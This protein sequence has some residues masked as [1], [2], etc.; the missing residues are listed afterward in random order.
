M[1]ETLPTAELE[2]FVDG[3]AREAMTRDHIAGATVAVVQNGQVLL[4]KGYG[5]AALAPW[6]PVNA[7]TTL[8]RLGPVSR[9]FTWMLVGEQIQAGRMRAEGP[10][11]L[12]LP[13]RLRLPDQG[14]ARPIHIQD[15]MDHTDG[16]ENRALGQAYERDARAIRPLAQYLREE[17]PRRVREPGALPVD[18]DYGSALAGEAVANATGDEFDTLAE[19]RIF[20]PMGLAH[21]SFRE[22]YPARSNLPAPLD[23]ALASQMSDSFEWTSQGLVRQPFAF[24]SQ[25]A[26]SGSASSTAA[27]MARFMS[28]VLPTTAVAAAWPWRS[29]LTPTDLPGGVVGLSEEGRAMSSFASIAFAPSLG[30]GVFVAANTDTAGPMTRDV[31]SQIIQRF[32]AGPMQAPVSGSGLLKARGALEGVYLDDRRAYGRLEGFV[33]RL[34]K[35]V[36][37]HVD[38]DETLRLDSGQTPAIYTVDGDA[39]NGRLSREGGFG[40]LMFSPAKPVARW[41]FPSSRKT[42]F[43]RA[44]LLDQTRTLEAL[45]GLIAVISL[46]ALADLRG[47]GRVALRESAAQRRARWLQATQAALWL[48]ALAFFGVWLEGSRGGGAVMYAWPGIPLVAASS[49][50]LVATLLSLPN[51]LLTPAVWRGGRRVES[52]NTGR[53]LVF[54]LTSLVFM[55]Y[56]ALLGAWGALAPW[57]A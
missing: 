52:W 40:A 32:Y 26:P 9:I 41:I 22:P 39:A 35:S 2:A 55:A 23:P 18:T 51:L 44:P 28:L 25:R 5:L 21:T 56:G 20:G 24:I 11:N 34:L 7:Q 31:A 8:F 37:V 48:A 38:N 6:R 17:R 3:L 10:V 54:T 33:D 46:G 13:A 14:F 36:S 42:T 27:D 53:K 43:E 57:S 30:L 1:S 16:L 45:S 49:C 15:L 4:E 47:G 12:Y 19:Q 50:A 29:G